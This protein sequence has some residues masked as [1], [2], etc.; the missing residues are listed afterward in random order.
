MPMNKARFVVLLLAVLAAGIG[1]GF[2]LTYANTIMPG[3]ATTDDRTFVAAFQGLERVFGSFETTVNWPV[4]FSF[5]GGPVLAATAAVLNRRNPKV[6]GLSVV[7]FILLVSAI[8]TT[9]AFNVPRNDKLTAAGD[10]NTIDVVQVRRDFDEGSWRAWNSVRS[11]TTGLAFICL[12]MALFALGQ[13]Q[14]AGSG[15]K[16]TT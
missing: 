6:A 11:A 4:M 10:P 9:I 5:F 16:K 8:F 7:A 3:L 13:E 14:H 2:F 1:T 12:S 15:K